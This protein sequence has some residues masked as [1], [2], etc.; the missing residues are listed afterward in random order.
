[1]WAPV[2]SVA[3]ETPAAIAPPLLARSTSDRGKDLLS[4]RRPLR[5]LLTSGGDERLIVPDGAVLNGYGCAPEPVSG[6]G[7]FSSSTASTISPYGWARASQAHMSLLAA[8]RGNRLEDAFEHRTEDMR[9]RLRALLQ[10]PVGTDIVFTP[11]GT[12]AALCASFVA[13]ALHGGALTRIVPLAEETGNG[14]VSATAGRHFGVRSALGSNVQKGGQIWGDPESASHV[15]IPG[16]D[17]IG[18]PLRMEDQDA[19]I[20]EA[21]SHGLRNGNKILLFAM[22]C[23]KTGLPMP[24]FG[25][26][27]HIASR[28]SGRV[29]IIIDAC[30]MRLSRAKLHKYLA[31]NFPVMIT[32]SKFFTGPAFCGALLVPPMMAALCRTIQQVPAG[33]LNYSGRSSWPV[34]WSGVRNGLDVALNMGELLRWESALAEMER[35]FAVPETFRSAAL[36]RLATSAAALIGNTSGMRQ[37]AVHGTGPCGQADEGMAAQTIFPFFLCPDGEP[38]PYRQTLGVYHALNREVARVAQHGSIGGR[39]YHVGQPVA[40]N[41]LDLDPAGALRVSSSARLISQA[42]DPSDPTGSERRIEHTVDDLAEALQRIA[43]LGR[44]AARDEVQGA[45][46]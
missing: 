40:I 10:L 4:L 1:M 27:Q 14:V 34:S 31:L 3:S 9:S 29:Q 24:S 45:T 11:S 46:P 5:E 2:Y 21:V 23:S 12:D 13:G 36:R 38:L 17:G 28:W 30:Q 22:D 33:L 32:G 19:A 25:C 18:M 8:E 44:A 6:I 43:Y 26:L 7:E 37:V 41:R 16:R 20:T 35:Y 39:A 42:W 15:C